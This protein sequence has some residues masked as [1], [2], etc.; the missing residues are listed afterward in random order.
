MNEGGNCHT[1]LLGLLEILPLLEGNECLVLARDY[2]DL[3][4][5]Q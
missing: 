1:K 5:E 2:A 4:G 3:D